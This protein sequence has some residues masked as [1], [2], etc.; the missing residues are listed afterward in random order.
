MEDAML[1]H[2]IVR[3]PEKRVFYLNMGGIPPN[4]VPA[5]MESTVSKLKRTP[6]INPET[7][8]YNLKFNM[9]NLLEDYYIPVRGGDSTTKIDTLGGYNGM[10]FKTLHIIEI[11]YLRL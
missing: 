4:E 1:I 7:G 3:A 2:R 5:F 6:Y 9:Q 8:D 10:V 11:S